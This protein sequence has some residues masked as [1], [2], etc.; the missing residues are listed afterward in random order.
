[1]LIKN[2]TRPIKANDWFV[3]FAGLFGIYGFIGQNSIA[4][5]AFLFFSNFRFYWEYQL[6]QVIQKERLTPCRLKGLTMAFNITSS[7]LILGSFIVVEAFQ[8]DFLLFG[9]VSSG[10]RILLALIPIG[11]S[12]G[13][14]AYSFFTWYYFNKTQK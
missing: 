7:I 14:V 6:Q 10:Y 3:G 11:L 13:S 9:V 8:G 2:N 12:T 1:M 5:L 4:C